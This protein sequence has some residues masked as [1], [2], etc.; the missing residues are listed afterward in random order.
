[1]TLTAAPVAAQ[2]EEI[3][4][5][6]RKVEESLQD[7]PLAISAFSSAEISQAA[8]ENLDDVAAFTPG[9]TFFNPIGEFLPVPVIRGVAPTDIFGEANAAIFVDGVYVSG[10][11]GLNFS[12][13]DLERIEVV[14]GPQSSLYG[15]NAFSGALN[16][17]TKRPSDVLEANTEV[18]LGSEGRTKGLV[19][20]SGPIVGD[21]LG[22]RLGLVYD[23]W[24]GSYDDPV[25]GVD[26]GGYKYR[27]YQGA[28]RFRPTNNFEM[29]GQVYYSNDEIDASPS[30]SVTA[31]CENV[32]PDDGANERLANY[33]GETPNL[34]AT[35]RELNVRYPTLDLGD[36]DIPKIPRSLGE[37]R[38]VTRASLEIS[39]DLGP[40]NITALTGF[41]N[42]EQQALTD[43]T[44]NLA[45]L[46]PF[47]YCTNGVADALG[48]GT[49][50]CFPGG[51]NGR[52]TAGLLQVTQPDETEEI[53]QE[54]RFTSRQ[55]AAFRYSI[56][57]YYYDVDFDGR[58]TGVIARS[59]D[60]PDFS[61]AAD[62][63]PADFTTFAPFINIGPGPELTIGDGAFG[64][65]FLNDN[66]DVTDEVTL[67]TKT[68]AW[69]V[70]GSV[71]LDFLEDFTAE[72]QVR[73]SDEKNDL[74]LPTA[75]VP[76]GSAF[77]T[78]IDD[79]WDFVTG[80]ASL[81]YRLND[82]TTIYSSLAR[83]E[84]SGGFD[85][86]NT[87]VLVPDPDNPPATM[88]VDIPVIVTFD[89][90][91]ILSAELGAK[92]TLLNGQ[93]RF[94]AAVYWSDWEDILLPQVFQS[95]PN[96]GLP[97]EQPEG[98]ITNAGD[99]TVWGTELQLDFL[100]GENFSGRLTGSWTDAELDN[101][102]L[103]SFADFPSFAP[104]GDVSG[105]KL[106]RQSE[107]QASGSLTYTQE[108]IRGWDFF[109]RGDVTYQGEQ[110]GGNDNQW[111]W[112]AHTYANFRTGV[113]GDNW[114][115]TL[116]VEN[117][118][119]D[120]GPTGG[121]RDVYF[122]NS[123]DP[124]QLEP[125]SSTPFNFFPW[126]LTMS[127]PRLRTYGITATYRFGGE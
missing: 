84:K 109:V 21:T 104:N 106:L 76:D 60:D 26:V 29:W 114:G 37:D 77:I 74:S 14:K 53:S 107:W 119:E 2:I 43:G 48:P 95:D 85:A 49:G 57:G 101:A 89:S 66:G 42:T 92:G 8:I 73:Y 72:L 51:T 61:D 11:E 24:D 15:R 122:G 12:F 102:T 96:S 116:W 41:S 54:I 99:A 58:E 65:W 50:L 70:F 124:L 80:R 81:K 68:E 113:D 33:C 25:G 35:N 7:V 91:T 52:F 36:N 20:V 56:G 126:R 111:K 83:G 64:P 94:D 27:T 103:E 19:S 18:T 97:F 59:I 86:E 105:R 40:G 115:V 117:A 88:N 125:P 118:F 38:E 112:P 121:F 120:D 34:T 100:L 93:L 4:V 98:F 123:D 127:H 44:R 63:V 108:W 82:D 32:G 87:T 71:E 67:I 110:Y 39:W 9:L 75:V 3:T 46:Q 69:A 16:F 13:L 78:A 1:L 45:F 47:V 22:G 79:S 31:N 10:R 90:E 17:V 28:L 5:T 23:E 6:A 30:T 55:D 62:S